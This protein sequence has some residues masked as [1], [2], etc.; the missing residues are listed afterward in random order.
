MIEQLY[1]VYRNDVY[2]FSL[3]IT[4]NKQKAE[5]IT[6]ETFIKVM[7]NLHHLKDENK[8]KTWLMSIALNTAT[9]LKRK[10]KLINFLPQLLN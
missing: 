8:R 9:A 3:Y 6:Q 10:R 2:H 4:N 1:D 5:D 7:K